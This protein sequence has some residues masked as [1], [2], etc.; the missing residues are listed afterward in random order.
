ML[1]SWAA[2]R[3]DI[4]GSLFIEAGIVIPVLVIM[5]LGGVEIARYALLQQKLDRLAMTTSDMVSQSET[6]S[7]PELDAILTASSSI[8]KPFAFGSDGVVIISSVSATGALPPKVDWQRS[9]GGTMTGMVSQLGVANQNATLP[10][11]FLVKS[12][13]NAIFAETYY[14]FTPMFLS[15]LIS[16]GLI[17]HRAVFRPRQSPLTTLCVTPC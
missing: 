8:M 13:E 15:S 3:R 5:T 10:A 17:Y 14:Q 7:I 16:P 6:I 1:R 11:G 2:F 12:T 4:R 9:G